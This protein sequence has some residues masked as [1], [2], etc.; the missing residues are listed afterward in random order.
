MQLFVWGWRHRKFSD[1]NL[2]QT[3]E[4]FVMVKTSK[5][6]HSTVLIKNTFI[7]CIKILVNSACLYIRKGEFEKPLWFQFRGICQNTVQVFFLE[8]YT[9]HRLETL[10]IS[11]VIFK[12]NPV[13]YLHWANNVEVWFFCCQYEQAVEQKSQAAGDLG[14]CYAYV[15]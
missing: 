8:I 7:S 2:V 3:F 6:T 11:L 5:P 10:Y 14:R 12:G 15:I 9:M 4:V 13:F 1:F